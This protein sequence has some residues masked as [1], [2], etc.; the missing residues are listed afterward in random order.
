MPA[1]DGVEDFQGE[2]H[3]TADWPHQPVDFTG[4]RVAVI[5]TGATGV[6]TIQEVAKTAGH[7]TVFQ[8]SPNYCAPLRNGPITAEEQRDIKARYPEI[9]E[10]CRA[11]FAGFM[12]DSDPRRALAVSPEEREA[13]YEQLY[14]EP[15]FG[16]WMG[17]FRDVLVDQEANDTITA[18]MK[19]KIRE[20]I[21]DP[22]IAE[23]MMP[24]NHGFGTRRVPMETNYYEVYNQDNVLLIDIRE[25]PIERITAAGI[26]TSAAAHDFDM[27][28]YATGFDA[29]TGGFERIDIRGAGGQRLKDK[30]AGGPK[31]YLGLQI[32]GFPNLFTLVGPHNAASFC[33]IP[34][35]IEQN[36]EWVSD[37]MRHVRDAGVKRVEAT[38][39]AEREWTAHVHETGEK[40]LFTKVDSWFMGI[41]SNLPGKQTR[42]FL[43]YA[44]GAPAYREKCDAVAANGYEGLVLR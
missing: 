9:F 20:R 29:V 21:N 7:L 30:W 36:V 18:F 28:I 4:K 43:L 8:R 39:E 12:H 13:F 24:T 41:N 16:I 25:T 17:N 37:L 6:Q 34:R 27:I 1:I 2:A 26:E 11:S 5:G 33:N 15:G 32:E 3:H 42:I 14:G 35:C 38:A 19:R 10:K 31:T 22:E 44:G 40:M 23:K